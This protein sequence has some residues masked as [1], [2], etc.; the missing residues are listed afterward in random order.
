M[1]KWTIAVV[2]ALVVVMGCWLIFG[3]PSFNADKVAQ[4]ETRMWQAYYAG[5]RVQLGLELISM[6]RNQ[7]GMSLLEAKE[8]AELLVSSAMD[9]RS[10]K[11]NYE[12]IALGDLTE[13]YRLIKRTSGRSFDP[14]EAARA[15]LA[16]WV[17]RR[18]PGQDSAEQVGEKIAELYA[19][20][21]GS[22]HPSL[23]TAGVLRAK[24]AELRDSGGENADW[25]RVEDLLKESYRELNKA[26]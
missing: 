6:L 22:D 21:C 8:T 16:W 18:T 1:T 7:Y 26:M 9:F 15:E 20:L 12:N 23:L 4:A 19:I 2:M 24:A 14:E 11:G 10:S 13:A 5:N 25:L 17:V 3:R